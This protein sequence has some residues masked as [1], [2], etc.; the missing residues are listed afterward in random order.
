[1]RSKEKIDF[2]NE[3]NIRVF[4]CDCLD[5]LQTIESNSVDLFLI[6]PPYL[7]S[8]KTNFKSGLP[9]GR[10]TDRFRVSMDFGEWDND[11]NALSDVVREAYR[12]LKKGGTFIC[13]YDLWKITE[14]STWMTESGFKQLR[15]IEWL[16][17]NPVPLNSSTNY[18]T[19]SRE[20]AISCV[21]GGKP[22]FNSKYDNGLYEYPICHNKDRFHPTQKPLPLI[23]DLI[24]KHS[25]PG[26]KVIDCFL[27]S[28]TTAM[29]C[30]KLH[31]EFVGC[32][33]DEDYYKKS[34]DSLYK[35]I[36]NER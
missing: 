6:D 28:G 13:F 3:R 18:L 24:E 20:V 31:R 2:L 29:G 11:F 33:L 14:L 34:I 26:D 21:K 36:L 19:N 8:R 17:T 23:M 22:T 32:E 12:V 25:N 16:K 9:T 30:A 4:N 27:G 7:V 1:M 5:L 10:D 15:F 35:E